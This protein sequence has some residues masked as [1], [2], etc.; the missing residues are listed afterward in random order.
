MQPE[1]AAGAAEWRGVVELPVRAPKGPKPPKKKRRQ[2]RSGA[3]AA[4][5]GGWPRSAMAAAGLAGGEVVGG[6][7]R[8]GMAIQSDGAEIG[9]ECDGSPEDVRSRVVAGR[10]GGHGHRVGEAG[11]AANKMAVGREPGI[12]LSGEGLEG[13]DEVVQRTLHRVGS[14]QEHGARNAKTM[15]ADVLEEVEG[16]TEQQT[17]KQHQAGGRPLAKRRRLQQTRR[18]VQEEGS[19]QQQQQQQR[20]CQGPPRWQD[21]FLAAGA[22][23][24]EE[25]LQEEEGDDGQPQQQQ[26]HEGQS[27]HKGQQQQLRSLQIVWQA[28]DDG[29]EADVGQDEQQGG[30]QP[31][32]GQ[33]PQPHQNPQLVSR[34][35]LGRRLASFAEVCGDGRRSGVCGAFGQDLAASK[36]IQV[37]LMVSEAVEMM[38]KG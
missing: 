5:P 33:Q 30:Q 24:E 37:Y 2:E 21:I 16:C 23:E 19:Y 25:V 6:G 4:S 7:K 10:R 22:D 32:Q 15:D 36:V 9:G 3:A 26:G 1:A 11:G 12:I 13:L 34:S 14:V 29:R 31:L 35:S 38:Q 28:E 20:E 8:V 18:Y 17:G 27:L